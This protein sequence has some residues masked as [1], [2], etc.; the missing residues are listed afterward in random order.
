MRWIAASNARDAF[1]SI[2][3]LEMQGPSDRHRI[4]E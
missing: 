4:V 2:P 3:I 1:L